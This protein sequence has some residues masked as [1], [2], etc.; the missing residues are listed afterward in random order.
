MRSIKIPLLFSASLFATFFL[1]ILNKYTRII[2]VI[3]QLAF[4]YCSARHKTENGFS[5][6]INMPALRK[7]T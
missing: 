5:W 7:I 1:N 2:S 3:Q 6:R 4:Y